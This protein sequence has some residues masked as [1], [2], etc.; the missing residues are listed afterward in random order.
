MNLL[1]AI[2]QQQPVADEAAIA[3]AIAAALFIL[4]IALAISLAINVAI[5]AMLHVCLS[6]VPAQYRKM[7]PWQVWLLMIPIFNF[8]W[9]FIVYQ[10]IQEAFYKYNISGKD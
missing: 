1:F 6:R 4:L 10:R 8:A 2:A 9:N 7:E 5:C 3:A